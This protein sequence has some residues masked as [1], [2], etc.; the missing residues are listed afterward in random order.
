MNMERKRE[1]N[2]Y[3]RQAYGNQRIYP[4]KGDYYGELILRMIDRK[5]FSGIDLEHIEALGFRLMP[6]DT[7]AASWIASIRAPVPA[8]PLDER[9][10][11]DQEN[12]WLLDRDEA[13]AKARKL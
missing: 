13:M 5:C 9:D 2:I 7:A 11:M 6:A 3:V 8:Q 4:V 10:V 12:Q 1:V